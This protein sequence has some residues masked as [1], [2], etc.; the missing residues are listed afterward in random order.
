MGGGG[1]GGRHMK[2]FPYEERGTGTI[3][4]MLKGRHK[5]V[6]GNLR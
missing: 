5:K 2:F 3:L 6:W 1:A 4:A